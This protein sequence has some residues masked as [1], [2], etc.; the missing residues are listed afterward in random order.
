[1][2]ALYYE[3][4]H[5]SSSTKTLAWA[6]FLQPKRYAVWASNWLHLEKY[7]STS[8]LFVSE[9]CTFWPVLT[10]WHLLWSTY[11]FWSTNIDIFDKLNSCD[12]GCAR[13]GMTVLLVFRQ[14]SSA[15][16]NCYKLCISVIIFHD[17]GVQQNSVFYNR[18]KLWVNR[19]ILHICPAMRKIGNYNNNNNN[20]TAYGK[21]TCNHIIRLSIT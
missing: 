15:L 16:L 20:N 1:M 19:W 8:A 14:H 18:D 17:V 5:S 2:T 21:C 9:K 10:S 4:K 13:N 7:R 6:T 12:T 3:A 11:C